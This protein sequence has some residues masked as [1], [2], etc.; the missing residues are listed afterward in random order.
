MCVMPWNSL[1]FGGKMYL[2]YVNFNCQFAASASC[3][4]APIS[5]IEL[6]LIST[7]RWLRIVASIMGLSLFLMRILSSDHLSILTFSFL[8][9]CCVEYSFFFFF[10]SIF[11]CHHRDVLINLLLFLWDRERHTNTFSEFVNQHVQLNLLFGHGS[12][13]TKMDFVM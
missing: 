9:I 1:S 12:T 10:P 8:Q 11:L 5:L 4:V 7:S 6:L 2:L 13:V 3:S